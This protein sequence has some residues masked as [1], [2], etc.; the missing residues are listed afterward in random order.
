MSLS[1]W[2]S[3]VRA[4]LGGAAGDDSPLLEFAPETPDEPIT[5]VRRRPLARTLLLS[6]GVAG[7]AFGAAAAM[8]MSRGQGIEHLFAASPVP[9][10]ASLTIRTAP[11]GAQVMIDGTARGLTPLT[12]QVPAGSHQVTVQSGP[13]QRAFTVNAS[14]GADI[15]RDF[16]FA[17][18]APATGTVAVVT[19]PEGA[20]VTIDG[21]AVGMAPVSIDLAPGTHHVSVASAAGKSERAIILKEGQN[22]SV[23]F[24]LGTGAVRANGWLQISA[25]FEVQLLEDGEVIGDGATRVMLPPGR[26]NLVILNASLAYR[27]TR[28]VTVGAGQTA[29]LRIDPPAVALNINA[30][31]WAEVTLDG[32][33]LGQTPIANAMVPIGARRLVFRH[34]DLGEREHNLVVTT[35][36]GQRIAVDLTK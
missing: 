21:A 26:H 22:A 5:P 30:R 27:E 28:T 16:E 33:S 34:P 32:V 2:L 31:P 20:A 3:R 10:A 11:D 9:G 4:R 7:I 1:G 23:V 24:S 29:A 36:P 12:L 18:A 19:E 35:R 17:A 14:A 15:I 25:P 13:Q 6:A 8:G